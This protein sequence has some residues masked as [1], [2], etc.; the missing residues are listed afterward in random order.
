MNGSPV[1]IEEL[2]RMIALRR[3]PRRTTADLRQTDPLAVMRRQYN[4]AAELTGN[5]NIGTMGSPDMSMIVNE[6][7]TNRRNYANT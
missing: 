2:V 4:T 5:Q 7:L 6:Y 3:K 1:Q